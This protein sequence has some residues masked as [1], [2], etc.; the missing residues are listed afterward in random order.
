MTEHDPT[1]L[2]RTIAQGLRDAYH[3]GPKFDIGIEAGGAI[4]AATAYAVQRL[5]DEDFGPA[6]AFKVACKPGQPVIMAPIYADRIFDSG[7]VVPAD[8]DAEI[9]IELEVGFRFLAP[10][11]DPSDPAFSDRLREAVSVV[12]AIEIVQ[13]RLTD[14]ESASPMLR[15]ADNQLNG[16]LVIGDELRDWQG[17]DLGTVGA[18]LSFGDE[19]FLDGQA[20]VPGGDAFR[21]LEALVRLV[22]N[23]CGGL[24]P[25]HVVITGSLNGLP[26]I[27][28]G[29]KVSGRIDGIGAVSADFPA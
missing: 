4:D 10:P 29:R 6:G 17:L 18:R 19:V 27:R 14:T 26:Y 3:G 15:L 20:P 11:P 16:G 21:N 8:G 25:G 7:A 9:G 22:G 2:A 12:A 13:T 28:R 5:L 1:A 23:H 24:R